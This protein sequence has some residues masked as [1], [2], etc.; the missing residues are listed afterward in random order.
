MGAMINFEEA[1]RIVEPRG[2]KRT[3][4]ETYDEDD[5]YNPNY[6]SWY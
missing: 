3:Y 4:K 6:D 1:P 2:R 5:H